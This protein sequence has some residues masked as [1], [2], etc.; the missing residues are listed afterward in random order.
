MRPLR[1]RCLRASDWRMTG[2][3]WNCEKGNVGKPG[4]MGHR[5]SCLCPGRSR[6]PLGRPSAMAR[7]GT[8]K[9]VCATSVSQ[10]VHRLPCSTFMKEIPKREHLNATVTVPPSKSY[11]VRALLLGAMSE[12]TT[13]ITNCLDADD[14]RYALEALRTIGYQIDGTFKTG[15]TIGPRVS[16]SANDVHVFVGNAGT[17][18]RFLTGWLAFTP[19]RFILQGEARMHER[20]IGDLVEVLLSIGAEVEYVDREGYPPLRIRGK[21]MRGGF[22]VAIA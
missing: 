11:S 13:T 2:W 21:K 4:S 5:H 19:G 16:M 6:L 20:P 15:V 1:Q 7:P 18:M 9:S 3:C 22:D 10:I 12:G 14:T 8:D 17:A